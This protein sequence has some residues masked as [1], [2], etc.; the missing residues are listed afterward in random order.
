MPHVALPTAQHLRTRLRRGVRGC[1]A[2]AAAWWCLM[3]AAAHANTLE[4]LLMPGKVANAHAKLEEDCSQCHDRTDKARMSSLCLACHKDIAAD[5]K[6]RTG[7][8]GRALPANTRCAGCHGDHKGRDAD[9]VG[10]E[11]TAFRHTQ[12]DFRL[13]GSHAEVACVSCHAPG[14]KFREAPSACYACHKKDDTHKGKLGRECGTCHGVVSFKQTKFDHDKTKFQLR[15]GHQ[16]V[17]C[18]A[19]HRDPT[20]KNAPTQC[21][22]CHAPDDVHRGGRGTDCAS[23]HSTVSWTQSKFNHLKETGFALEGRH[24]K[25]SCNA[26][27][28]GGDF[29]APLP[30]TCNGC[31]AAEDSHAGRFGDDCATCH[32]ADAWKPV[33]YDHFAKH[34]WALKGKHEKLGCHDCH[35]GN[36][37]QQKLPKDCVGCHRADDVHAGGMGTDCASCHRETGWRDSVRFDHDLTRFPL[38]GLHAAVGCEQCHAD[39]RYR[40]TPAKCVACHKDE[41]AHKGSLGEECATCHNPNGWAHWQFDHGTTGFV[42]DGSHGKL[43]CANCHVKPAYE[44]KLTRECAACHARDDVHD[45][46]FGRDCGRCHTT[47]T[48][49]GASPRR[50]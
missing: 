31:H 32:K 46:A 3:P 12:T 13:E 6:S 2:L 37:K 8:H 47:R 36:A 23:C 11:A 50:R 15:G 5:V 30:K 42:L 27:H 24:E 40:G 17:A 34:K 33:A 18:A 29:K 4:T 26:C 44:V 7:F 22:A 14:K 43:A 48:F 19:C 21:N 9:I 45:G 1:L 20:F 38:V 35:T 16:K 10:L 41:D 25:I 28:K 49:K 39:Q